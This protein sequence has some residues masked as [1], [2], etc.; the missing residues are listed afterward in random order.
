MLKL[1]LCWTQK[2]KKKKK[3]KKKLIIV[4]FGYY[5]SFAYS[6]EDAKRKSLKNIKNIREDGK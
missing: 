3:K 5:E 1:L 4:K 2:K 6:A